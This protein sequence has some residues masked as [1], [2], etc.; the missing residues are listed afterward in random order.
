MMQIPHHATG[1]GTGTSAP[2]TSDTIEEAHKLLAH[3]SEGGLEGSKADQ[4][5]DPATGQGETPHNGG[6]RELFDISGI[7]TATEH[8]RYGMT[9]VSRDT[10][11]VVGQ[12]QFAHPDELD[13][14]RARG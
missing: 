5:A 1:T 10:L 2:D 3:P 6:E 7:A 9:S 4:L 11:M 13:R 8:D 12:Y 14:R